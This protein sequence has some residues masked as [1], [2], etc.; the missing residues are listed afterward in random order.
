MSTDIG[1]STAD[2]FDTVFAADMETTLAEVAGSVHGTAD[3]QALHHRLI[4]AAVA[5]IPGV[6]RASLMVL[7]PSGLFRTSAASDPV[8]AAIDAI[9]RQTGEGPCLDAIVDQRPQLVPDLTTSQ[10]WPELTARVLAATPVR[11]S[12]GFRIVIDEVKY[13]ALNLFAD[14]DHALTEDSA[15]VGVLFAAPL[16]VRMW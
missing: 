15:R 4:D 8:A 12:A 2:R 3:Q 1:D 9:E 16:C 14:R 5:T 10:A 13:G 11:G 7:E 6:D